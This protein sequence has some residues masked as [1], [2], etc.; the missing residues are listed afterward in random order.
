M[1]KYI[2]MMNCSKDSVYKKIYA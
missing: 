2:L 1:Y